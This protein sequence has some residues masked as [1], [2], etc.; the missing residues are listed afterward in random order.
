[1]GDF[2]AGDNIAWFLRVKDSGGNAPIVSTVMNIMVVNES[3]LRKKQTG[4]ME[5]LQVQLAALLRMQKEARGSSDKLQAMIDAAE[6]DDFGKLCEPLEGKQAAVRLRCKTI[7]DWMTDPIFETL[8]M[9]QALQRLRSGPMVTVMESI[10]AL[11]STAFD[12]KRAEVLG[13]V[14]AT[15]DIIIRE[16]EKLLERLP[17]IINQLKEGKSA[18]DIAEELP[19]KKMEWYKQKLLEFIEE[20]RKVVE[21]TRELERIPPEDWTEREEEMQREIEAIEEKW[22]KFFEENRDDFSKLPFQDFSDGRQ[23]DEFVEIYQAVTKAYEAIKDHG[24]EIAVPLEQAGAE[25]AEELVHNIEAWLPDTPDRD[26][27]GPVEEPLTQDEIPMAELPEELEDIVGDL[28]EE[29]EDMAD[30]VEDV[31]SSWADSLDEGAGWDCQDG[32]I[33]NMSAKGKTGNRMPNNNE[34]AGRSG[35][36]RSGKSSGQFVEKSA[37]GK[38]GRETPTRLTK[39]PFESGEVDD[40]SEDPVSGS[41]GGGKVSGQ[42]GQ[43]LQGPPPPEVDKEMG[44]LA[45]NQAELMSRAEKLLHELRKRRFPTK[46]VE[47]AIEEIKEIEKQLREGAHQD[48]SARIRSVVKKLRDAEKAIGEQVK[49]NRER[50]RNLPERDREG[51]NSATDDSVPPDYKELVE[52]YYRA[53]A[54]EGKKKE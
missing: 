50:R 31:S 37:T 5:D 32:P 14:M 26:R 4:L 8:L 30:D 23:V 53:L 19:E 47:R 54:E 16:L 17:S 11:K 29:E 28:I 2:K 21:M 45:G 52:E 9:K 24:H 35:E 34:I 42:G 7:V 39:D 38:G 25:K 36:G 46:D 48:L 44:R 41:S 15:Q 51:I 40:R 27:G 22:Q 33:S 3:E 20:Q 18:E 1:M 6:T 13:G 10:S 49:I 12:E 43:G